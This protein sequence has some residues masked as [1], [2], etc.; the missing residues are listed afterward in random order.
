MTEISRSNTTSVS[1][2]QQ[3]YLFRDR[4]LEM[5]SKR[6]SKGKRH[7]GANHLIAGTTAGVVTTAALYPLDLV[8]TRYQVY[9]KGPSPY[10]SLGTAFRTIIREEGARALYQGLGP[11]LL[12]N[13]V[14]WGGFFY[15][16]EKI[17]TAIRARVPQ[18]ADLGAVHHLGAGYVAGAMMVLATNP[19][20]MIKTRMQLQDKKAKSGG[21]RPYSG[22]MDA[23]RTITREEGP[24][25]LYK[26][27]VPALM[28]CGQGAVQFA[29]YEWL[30]ARV[31][32]RNENTPQESLLMGGASKIL[33]TLVTYPTQYLHR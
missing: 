8:K 13:A 24:L 14:A 2:R 11:A 12:G 30:K 26:G 25:A 18:E 33:S 6:E 3:Q 32:K 4:V 15:C 7:Y 21:V 31:P 20:W 23:V 19:V 28:L 10:K 16:Y 1:T 27:A 9:D 22:L 29:V 5:F 17:K